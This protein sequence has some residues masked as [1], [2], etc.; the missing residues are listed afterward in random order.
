M[1]NS[2]LPQ[3]PK[4]LDEEAVKNGD[5]PF[6]EVNCARKTVVD[7]FRSRNMLT[8]L[9]SSDVWLEPLVG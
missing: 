8:A 1:N 2:K 7:D 6:V 9:K 5:F 3:I 4:S